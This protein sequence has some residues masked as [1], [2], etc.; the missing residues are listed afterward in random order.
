M[1]EEKIVMT[2]DP[3]THTIPTKGGTIGIKLMNNSAKDKAMFR[4][5]CTNN[6]DYRVLPAYGFVDPSN[7]TDIS[8][9]RFP[10]PPKDD[11]FVV[12]Y[13]KA[14][15]DE[16]DARRAF[17]LYIIPDGQLAITLSTTDCN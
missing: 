10:G 7:S 4:I 14:P 8:I 3:T 9:V 17:P 12:I 11:K 2:A 5:T 16:P 6:M 13:A 15:E 1:K